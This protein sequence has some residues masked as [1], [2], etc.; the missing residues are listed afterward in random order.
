MHKVSLS[1]QKQGH[2]N[3]NKSMCEECMLNMIKLAALWEATSPAKS[4]EDIP[5]AYGN[6][7]SP[8]CFPDLGLLSKHDSTHPWASWRLSKGRGKGGGIFLGVV[9]ARFKMRVDLC[10][11]LV[12]QNAKRTMCGLDSCRKQCSSGKEGP[13]EMGTGTPGALQVQESPTQHFACIWIAEPP[14]AVPFCRPLVSHVA[15]LAVHPNK[16][17]VEARC[18]HVLFWIELIWIL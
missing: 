14:Q 1:K 2:W 15:Q 5:N 17:I 3:G 6:L 13:S 18:K 4:T 16:H 7:I 10:R 12:S 8:H 11:L 9:R